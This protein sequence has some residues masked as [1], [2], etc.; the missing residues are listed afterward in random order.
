MSALLFGTIS[1]PMQKWVIWNSIE[2]KDNQDGSVDKG[3]SVSSD[4]PPN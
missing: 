4:L 3:G 1:H 2:Q